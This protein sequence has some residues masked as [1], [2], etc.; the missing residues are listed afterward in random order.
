M[1]GVAGAG[2]LTGWRVL[3]PRPID[4]AGE[5][6]SLLRAVGAEP[7]AVP[8]IAI[9]PPTDPG[10]LD[11]ALVDL[12]SSLFTWVG[13]TS[14]NAV[15]AVVR[16]AAQLGID[17]AVPADTRVAAVG[18]GTAAALR[19]AGLPVDL[20]PTG[21]GSADVIAELWPRA[22]SGETVLL[23]RSDIARPA[24]PDALLAKGYRVEAVAAYRTVVLPLP[25]ELM[26]DLA[27]D[28]FDAILLT[29]PSTVSALADAPLGPAILL[30]AI[31]Q[32]DRHCRG[33]R[34]TPGQ[35][36]RVAAH[37]HSTG[38]RPGRRRT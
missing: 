10:P 15:D 5:L 7:V 27:A 23:P 21:K 3:I 26:T 32:A 33:V 31:G 11:L 2:P 18:P 36:R 12:G 28:R 37:C 14:A 24:L 22:R 29:S 16:R 35:L 20:V 34:R 8:L 13:F 1:T 30:G 19:G 38:R 9:E 6:S 25:A 17:P 4:Q